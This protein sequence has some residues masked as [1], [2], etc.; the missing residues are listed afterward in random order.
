MREHAPQKIDQRRRRPPAMR[1]RERGREHLTAQT[2]G[3]MRHRVTQKGTREEDRNETYGSS[4]RGS[5]R[6]RK[7]Y[8]R[9]ESPSRLM[10]GTAAASVAMSSGN[11]AGCYLSRSGV[12]MAAADLHGHTLVIREAPTSWVFQDGQTEL[13]IQPRGKAIIPDAAAQNRS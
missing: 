6:S 2:C 11:P 3:E 8:G 12:P 9:L 4:F 13:T 10:S 5:L 1:F 7:G